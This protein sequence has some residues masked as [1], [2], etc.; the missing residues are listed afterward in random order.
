MVML[1]MQQIYQEMAAEKL[2][3]RL[4]ILAVAWGTF[5]I[6][7]MLA[8]GEGLRQGLMRSSQSNADSLLYITGGYASQTTGH[9][10][11]GKALSLQVDD[12][13]LLR[14][15]PFIERAEVS[16]IWNQPVRRNNNYTWQE[17]IAV[18]PEY[19]SLTGIEITEGGRWI[20]PLDNQQ[21]RSVVVL[22]YKAAVQL[23]NTQDNDLSWMGPQMLSVNPVG[24]T[25]KIGTQNFTVIGLITKTTTQMEGIPADYAIFIPLNTWKKFNPSSAIMAIN[26]QLNTMVDRKK[27]A[28][29]IKQIIARKYSASVSDLQLLQVEDMLLRQK[30]LLRFLF[31]LQGFL[32]IIGLITLGV[33]GIGIANAMY[34]TVKRSTR[35]IGVRMAVGATPTTIK[36]HYLAQ[37]LLTMFMGGLTG[38]GATYVLITLLKHASFKN[39]ILFEQLEEPLPELSFTITLLVIVALTIIGVIAAWFPANRAANIT[40]LEALQSE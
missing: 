32:G 36:L 1:S 12:A 14:A 22:G 5:C 6:A 25:I 16:A 9:F 3:L 18:N 30:S 23:Y 7:T 17:P 15:L 19:Q 33:A 4:T 13:D 26:V 34:A 39:S 8:T 29:V 10:F 27:A 28:K 38:L 35:D 31:G 37:A 40:P 21:Q 11:E 2:R 20:N 24:Q